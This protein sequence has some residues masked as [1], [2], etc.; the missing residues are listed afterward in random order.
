MLPSL[1]HF[2]A[3]PKLAMKQGLRGETRAQR[4]GDF[5]DNSYIKCPA[6]LS[7]IQMHENDAHSEGLNE[8]HL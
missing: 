4:Q 7:L 1:F 2:M 6:I 5:K 3:T 8:T